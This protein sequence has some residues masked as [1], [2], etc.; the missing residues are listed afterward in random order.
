[1][2]ITKQSL[3]STC[4]EQSKLKSSIIELAALQ[5]KWKLNFLQKAEN[6][7]SGRIILPGT[8]A[9][10]YFVGNP[11]KWKE[12]PVTDKEYVWSLNRMYHWNDFILAFYLTEDKSYI[13]KIKNELL[14]WIKECPPPQITKDDDLILKRFNSVTPWRTLEVGIRMFEVWPNA[15]KFLVSQNYLNEAELEII[16]QS[17][18]QHGEVLKSISPILWPNA[19]H[20]HYLMENLGLLYLSNLYPEFN[21]P[22]EWSAYANNQI[23]RCVNTQ[24]SQEGA[25]TEGCPTYHNICMDFFCLWIILCNEAGITISEQLLCLIQKG[26]DYSLTCFRPCGGSVPWGDSDED[27]GAVKSAILAYRAFKNDKWLAVLRRLLGVQ[28]L[29]EKC[30]SYIIEI[31]GNDVFEIIEN[32][33]EKNDIPCFSFQK[34]IN[35]VAYR[36]SWKADAFSVHFG[37]HM[38]NGNGHSHI[39][40]LSFDFTALGDSLLV[41]PGRF[42]Y[43]E[44]NDRE[45]F[46]SPQMHNCLLINNQAPYKYVSSW[47]FSHEKDGSIIKA[48]SDND[49]FWAIGSHTCYYPKI[50]TRLIALI[51][52]SFLLVWDKVSH[53]END[54]KISLYFNVDTNN[55]CLSNG[56]YTAKGKNGAN[57]FIK[58]L[59]GLDSMVLDG[60]AA[61]LIDVRRKTK[62]ICY[63][64]NA[65]K[66][67]Y[68]T[69]IAPFTEKL[70][71]A[72]C[73]EI[74][75]SEKGSC[76]TAVVNGESY[77]LCWNESNFILEKQ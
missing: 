9:L 33:V 5:P 19:N 29:K 56:G 20:N 3:Q 67:E 66:G 11:P 45:L 42:T 58:S 59:S 53:L 30:L 75:Y 54:D 72:A 57:A 43:D 24:L 28:P 31:G 22:K 27:Y 13:E 35:Q 52:K 76:I 10:P 61:E 34:A 8:S 16:A 36:T 63:E 68:I 65:A 70:P 46:K 55:L 60:Y 17:L 74:S 51:Q 14:D 69:L 4:Q 6:E 40:P 77:L 1:M 64:D 12:Q 21:I 2:K 18:Y 26:L 39:D 48:A 62:R 37:C 49:N 7:L 15:I 47:R 38:P 25:Q 32:S 71:D 44:A 50:H 23:I 73:S 41:D